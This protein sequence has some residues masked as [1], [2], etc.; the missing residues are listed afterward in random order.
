MLLIASLWVVH[1]AFQTLRTG[2]TRD[3]QILH[4]QGG[5]LVT[6][7]QGQHVDAYMKGCDSTVVARMERYL[8]EV[9]R[10]SLFR[11]RKIPLCDTVPAAGSCS[12]CCPVSAGVW[13]TGNG[14]MGGWIISGTPGNA[15]WERIR[16]HPGSFILLTGEPRIPS[17]GLD[18]LIMLTEVIADG[19]NRN[20]FVERMEAHHPSIHATRVRGAYV[21]SW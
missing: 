6:I 11:I 18:D 7:R 16:H 21:E 3:I 2:R 9:W 17:R 19:S 15:A 8:D 10:P 20:W 14:E 13:R 1:S 5:S 4:F 12:V